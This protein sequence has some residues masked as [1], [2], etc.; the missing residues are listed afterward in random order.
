MDNQN[1]CPAC[2]AEMRWQQAG[3]SQRTGRPYNGF[4]TCPNRCPKNQGGFSGQVAR[5]GI[6]TDPMKQVIDYK[7][8]SIE[9]AQD[10]KEESIRIL[11]SKN[12]AADITVALLEKGFIQP[13]DI[14]V[15]FAKYCTYIYE[16]EPVDKTPQ[17]EYNEFNDEV[18]VENI[19]F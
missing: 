6:Q 12:G 11:N 14:E 7:G 5:T 19:P 17:P 10:R 9:Q 1:T 15:T 4:F 13:K 16:F 8:K 2:G 3:V 18:R